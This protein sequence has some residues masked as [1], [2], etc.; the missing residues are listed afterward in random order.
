MLSSFFNVINIKKSTPEESSPLESTLMH[1]Q[2]WEE[3]QFTYTLEVWDCY[4]LN[5]TDTFNLFAINNC[6]AFVISNRRESADRGS[7]TLPGPFP[8]N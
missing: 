6:N 2:H 8:A 5:R 1:C 7:Y 4:E 3:A